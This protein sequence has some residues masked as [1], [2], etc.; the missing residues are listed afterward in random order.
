MSQF[1][2]KAFG[3]RNFPPLARLRTF[4]AA[5]RLQSFALAAQELHLT[6][7]AISHQIRDLERHF[8]RALFE[9]H[10][11]RVQTTREGQRLFEGLARLFDALEATCAEVQLPSHDEVL[12]LHCAPS[13]ALKW[14]GPR[15]PAFLGQH[16]G[17]NIRLTT[18]AEPV[19]LSVM[20]DID[21]VLS[22]GAPRQQAGLDTRSLDDELIA[23]MVSPS[24][25]IDRESAAKAIQRLVLIESQLS[26]VDWAHWFQINDLALPPGPRQSFDRAAMAIAAAV[27]GLGVALEST[28]LA[29]RELERGELVVLGGKRLKTV[30]RPLH[31]VSVR[32]TDQHR[33][34]VAAFVNWIQAQAAGA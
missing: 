3:M 15:L 20:R 29:W 24:L 17:L 7:S 27:D 4:E 30:R 16:P 31:F 19:D 18:G 14:L 23:P 11:R 33:V 9:R 10:H 6:A 26:P 1:H 12:A 34:P 28:R 13:L 8:G 22:Y 25:L 5:A 32:S 21:V 2:L